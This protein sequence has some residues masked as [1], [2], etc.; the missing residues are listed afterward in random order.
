MSQICTLE[1]LIGRMSAILRPDWFAGA[2]Y[3]GHVTCEVRIYNVSLRLHRAPLAKVGPFHLT[4]TRIN[5]KT[6]CIAKNKCHE[7]QEVRTWTPHHTCQENNMYIFAFFVFHLFYVM[8]EKRQKIL[9]SFC[10]SLILSNACVFDHEDHETK[11]LVFGN[12]LDPCSWFQKD[13]PRAHIEFLY[14]NNQ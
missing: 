8:Q 11:R 3:S 5:S 14:H 4:L 7:R 6:N 10:N 1:T 2:L 12:A 9:L 13:K